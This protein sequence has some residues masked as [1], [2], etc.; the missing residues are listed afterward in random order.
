MPNPY[1]Q[2]FKAP[3]AKGFAAAGFFARLPIAMAPIGI[4]AML[5][6]THGEYWL[7][8]AVSATFALT[9]AFV[10]P[11]ISRL[12]DRRGQS[13]V[14]TPFATISVIAFL[15][16]IVAA[17]RD[18]PLWTLFAAALAAATMPSIPAMVRSRWTEIFHGRP[19]LNTAF[20]FESVADELVYIAGASLSVGL[21][22]SFFPEAG[23]LASTLFLAFGTA[24]FVLQRSTEPGIRPAGDGPAH[25][26][27]R[28]R[29]VQIV[30]LAL[31]FVGAIFA[32]AEVSSVA[33][34]KALGQPGAAS[35][36]IGVYAVG[37]F[38]IG[39]V[40]GALNLKMPLQR[41]LAIAVAVIAFTTLPL[42]FADTVPL[43]A[44][45]VFVSGLAVSP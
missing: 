22:V 25:S 2:I 28:L 3:G 45:A 36:V 39:I 9:N 17:N 29:S 20:A 38:L 4:V 19:E 6:Q 23:M 32:T 18:W 24:A 1:R 11:Q 7:A 14:L 35:L 15:A 33:I 40:I 43:L 31:I 30:T 42:L 8:G 12:V 26:A 27:I 10:A 37:S 5:S 41:Q 16:L 21:S 13:A 44:V 34:T